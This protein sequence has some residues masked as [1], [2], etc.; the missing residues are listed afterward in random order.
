MID[1]DQSLTSEA[2]DLDFRE[3]FDSKMSSS[4]PWDQIFAL[5][6]IYSVLQSFEGKKLDQADKALIQGI[7]SRKQHNFKHLDKIVKA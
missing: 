2:S 4:N 7:Y 5:L 6:K 1:P 3:N